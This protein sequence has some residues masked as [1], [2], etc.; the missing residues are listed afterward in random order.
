MLKDETRAKVLCLAMRLEIEEYNSKAYYKLVDKFQTS[1]N[2]KFKA[3]LLNFLKSTSAMT[4]RLYCQLLKDIDNESIEK[5]NS[6]IAFQNSFK[7]FKNKFKKLAIN[8]KNWCCTQEVFEF[9]MVA[10]LLCGFIGKDLMR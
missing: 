10:L 9:C 6:S 3:D 4:Q 5:I 2:Y 7:A 1:K 8:F